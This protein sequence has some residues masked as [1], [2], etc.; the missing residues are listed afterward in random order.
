MWRHQRTYAIGGLENV[1]YFDN[2]DKLLVLSSQGLGVIDCYT[3]T[4]V[5]RSDEEWWP[6]FVQE[7]NTLRLIPGYS[8]TTV[9]V[10]GLHN[11]TGLL[12]KT[13]ENWQLSI[14]EPRADDPPFQHF[15]IQEVCLENVNSMEKLVITKDG[16][17]EFR[18]FGFSDSGKSLFAA[19]SCELVV[20]KR[21]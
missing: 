17:C 16:P 7:T 10:F 2:E 3:G 5:F 13:F 18:A 15:T 20:W 9:K 1:G 11:V 21:D 4:K 12:P 8:D 6:L 19:S 14:S